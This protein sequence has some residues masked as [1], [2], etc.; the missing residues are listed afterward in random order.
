VG[1]T[2]VLRNRPRDLT[3]EFPQGALILENISSGPVPLE[4]GGVERI[5]L[6]GGAG[7]YHV[8]GWYRGREQAAAAVAELWD[9]DEVGEDVAA[10]FAE[11]DGLE[12]YLLQIWVPAQEV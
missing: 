1:P 8:R 7:A 2:L 3:V 11:F 4:P 5:T 12:E 6:P 9:A 10:A